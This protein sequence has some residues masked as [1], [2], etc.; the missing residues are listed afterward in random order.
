MHSTDEGTT[1][2]DVTPG[3][4]ATIFGFLA[5]NDVQA[6]VASPSTS[7]DIDVFVTRDGGVSW[8]STSIRVDNAAGGWNSVFIAMADEG[9]GLLSVETIHGASTAEVVLFRTDDGGSSWT[10]LGPQDLVGPLAFSD[11]DHVWASAEPEGQTLLE[12]TDGGV[13]W[14]PVTL[15][16]PSTNEFTTV[17]TPQFYASDG[18]V[19]VMQGQ[20]LLTFHSADAGQTWT[21]LNQS[22]TDS[23]AALPAAFV[24]F[25]VADPNH[26]Y[27]GF[28][29]QLLETGV[30]ASA[31]TPVGLPIPGFVT[32]IDG[33]DDHAAA[34]LEQS[35]CSKSANSC[36]VASTVVET[37]NAGG[38][39]SVADP[40]P[41]T[42]T[43]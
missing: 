12:S 14:S 33:L 24:P 29:G 30:N 7:G 1:W 25:A 27:A 41:L 11:A 4:V 23:K 5:F 3:K 38:S 31:W 17:G 40:P 21:E 28:R 20:T 22:V 36:L 15:P 2:V 10:Q 9:R 43:H 8:T 18:V 37:A 42:S 39:W 35:S 13:T 34:V 26:I 6:Y 32:S 19:L 16:M